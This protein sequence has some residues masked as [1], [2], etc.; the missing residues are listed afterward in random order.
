MT[1]RQQIAAM[2]MA[3]IAGVDETGRGC[4]AGPVYAAAVILPPKHGLRG[5]DDSKKLTAAEREK[6]VPKI[7]RRALAWAVGVASLEEIERLNILHAALL[8]MQRA[9]EA[10]A[11]APAAI[12][13][14]GTFSPKVTCPAETIV[15]GDAK[16]TSI[17]AASILAKV[18][19][20]D[21]MRRWHGEY[22]EYSFHTNK[23]YGTPEHLQA[24]Q[25]RGPCAIHRR[26]F[27]PVAQ[28]SLQ[29]VMEGED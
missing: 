10:L 27:G 14:D 6:L 18:A 20:D 16:V 21:E 12:R 24:L 8:A 19:R 4:L 5:L 1:P 28:M 13:V 9:V 29:L 7:Q 3:T 11:V 15:G 25:V 2:D 22:P 26:L 23:G 17:M